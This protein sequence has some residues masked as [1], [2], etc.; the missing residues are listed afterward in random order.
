MHNDKCSPK[1][2]TPTACDSTVVSM[3]ATFSTELW[4]GKMLQICHYYVY[5][6]HKKTNDILFES[7][8]TSEVLHFSHMWYICQEG[9]QPADYGGQWHKVQ[10][11]YTRTEGG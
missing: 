4:A 7:P 5:V 1:H 9:V 11:H 10:S 6:T 2:N 8:K 3:S